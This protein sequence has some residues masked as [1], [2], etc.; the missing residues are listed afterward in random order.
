MKRNNKLKYLPNLSHNL[1]KQLFAFQGKYEKD[2]NNLRT[3]RNE[4]K[5]DANVISLN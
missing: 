5:D 3:E 1:F 4:N 2:N